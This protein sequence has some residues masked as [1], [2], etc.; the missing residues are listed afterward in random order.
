MPGPKRTVGE[1][2]SDRI[3]QFQDLGARVVSI[4]T[5]EFGPDH[6]VVFAQL[7]FE[8]A[9]PVSLAALEHITEKPDGTPHRAKY[10]YHAAQGDRFL[11][12]Y[13]RDP[14]IHPEMPEHRHTDDSD[15]R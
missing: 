3:A 2:L 8:G 10:S 15:R 1:Y 7:V 12:R 9:A 14:K 4:T 13:D 6:A 5:Q 11:F